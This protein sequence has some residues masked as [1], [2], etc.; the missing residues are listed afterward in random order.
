MFR[1][2]IGNLSTDVTEG[3]LRGLFEEQGVAVNNILLKRS[4]AFVDCP[5]QE[6]VD[7]AIE[8]LNGKMRSCSCNMSQF[9]IKCERDKLNSCEVMYQERLH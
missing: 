2:Y 1:L 9:L 4:F 6:N 5:D 3:T 7:K 8:N